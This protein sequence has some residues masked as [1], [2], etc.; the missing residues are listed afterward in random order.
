M[1]NIAVT[2]TVALWA[3]AAFGTSIGLFSTPD[4]SSCSLKVLSGNAATLYVRAS[5]NGL[6]TNE[7]LTTA[8]FKIVGLPQGW[9]AFLTPNP[10]TFT[11]GD[12]F[13]AI[14]A[15]ITF[16][17]D[18]QRGT[19]IDLG[20]ATLIATSPVQD[21]VLRVTG[22]T[23]PPNP[24]FPCPLIVVIC[25]DRACDTI[26]CAEGGELLV[27]ANTDCNVGVEMKSWGEVRNLY[28]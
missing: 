17:S 26:Y 12:P 28:R 9:F 27:N 24:R 4:C 5:T 3:S 11:T 13:G 20:S 25:S 8:N 6:P 21:W 18:S 15:T 19:C 16:R 14:G 7:S 10:E 2:I 23:P 22:S 1:K